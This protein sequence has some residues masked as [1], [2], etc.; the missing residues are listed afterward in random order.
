MGKLDVV[1][2][3]TP[4]ISP[5]KR[6]RHVVTL[7]LIGIVA[8][9]TC[10]RF[11][12]IPL[13]PIEAPSWNSS[14]PYGTFPRPDDPFQFLPCTSETLPA[15]EDKHHERS[16]AAQY[17]PNPEHWSWGNATTTTDDN[18][19]KYHGRGIYLCGYLDVPLDYT[20]ESDSR[21]V[22]LAVNKYQVSGLTKVNDK[23]AGSN[24]AGKKSERTI[25]LNPGGPGGS[26][27]SYLWR[28][29]EQV[30]KRFSE[31]RFDV[32]SWDPR[33]KTLTWDTNSLHC[34]PHDIPHC[35]L[36]CIP[37]CSPHYAFLLSSLDASLL[38]SLNTSLLSSLNTSLPSSLLTLLI[39]SLDASLLSSLLSLLNAPLLSSLC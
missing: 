23:G 1:Q 29:A 8:V 10:W 5:G 30:T 18:H 28:S 33:G 35:M 21:I 25:V 12:K 26:G 32:L 15:L 39:N 11:A 19:D 37:H 31:G 4:S 20:N 6:D 38:S 17:D 2:E 14:S 3:P 27:T 13:L 36:H 9:S 22:R 7:L 24:G 16:W 34:P